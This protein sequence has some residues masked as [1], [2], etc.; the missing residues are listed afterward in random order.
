MGVLQGCGDLLDIGDRRLKGETGA[1]RVTL[2][3]G[4]AWRIVHDEKG[5][6]LLHSKLVNAHNIWMIQ[7]SE[8]LGLGEEVLYILI[9]Q[10]NVQHFEGGAAFQI[11]VLTKI[12]F[13]EATPSK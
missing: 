8:H 13:C 7:A 11:D 3:Q 4:P 9:L 2:A 1:T 5:R 6:S 10:R 12:D